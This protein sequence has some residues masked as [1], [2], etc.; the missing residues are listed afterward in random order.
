MN[1]IPVN[2]IKL[3]NHYIILSRCPLLFLYLCIIVLKIM[4][5]LLLIKFL[6]CKASATKYILYHISLGKLM[7][8]YDNQ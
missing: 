6:K 8:N 2:L 4:F 1:S 3:Q 5:K 7:I